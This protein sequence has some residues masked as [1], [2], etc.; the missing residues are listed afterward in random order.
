MDQ[1]VIFLTTEQVERLHTNQILLYGRA[2]G[3]R[4][5]VC[6]NPP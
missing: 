2:P 3:L 4:I 5:E 1:Y 6:L